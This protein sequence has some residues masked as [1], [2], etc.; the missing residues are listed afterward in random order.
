MSGL[1]NIIKEIDHKAELEAGQII[2]EAKEYCDKYLAQENEKIRNE[3]A[4][5]EKKAKQERELY[6]SKANSGAEFSERN[7]VLGAKQLN[8]NLALEKA[9]EKMI[10][11]PDQEYFEMLL[12]ILKANVVGKQGEILLGKKDLDRI[13]TGF[14]ADANQIATEVGGKLALVKEAADISDGFIL[15]YGLIE[16]NCTLQSLIDTK[17]EQLKDVASGKL[18]G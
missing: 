5:F 4:D 8:I 18:F 10:S 14:E 1:D 9:Y 13:P 3:V 2:A 7:A 6:I 11:L 12:K 16:E 15:R 17:L